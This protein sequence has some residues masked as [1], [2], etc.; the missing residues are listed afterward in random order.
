[1]TSAETL[2]SGNMSY[3]ET[4]L[5]SRFG[6]LHPDQVRRC[7]LESVAE[8]DDARVRTYLVVLIE[9]AATERLRVLERELATSL[10]R[11]TTTVAYRPRPLRPM[12]ATTVAPPAPDIV[13]RQPS[14]D[15]ETTVSGRA[16][17]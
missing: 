16:R 14:A 15:R 4:R 9:R 11:A 1:M 5:V 17:P 12:S 3:L 6:Q 10:D 2:D 7:L 13:S 8:F